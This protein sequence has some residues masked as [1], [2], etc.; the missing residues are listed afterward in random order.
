MENI[1][2]SIA[3]ARV[4]SRLNQREFADKI[5]VSHL[6]FGFDF[7]EFLST[8]S[9][10]SYSDQDTSYTVGLEDCSKL[11]TLLEK[12]KKIGFSQAELEQIC[13]K[14]WHHLIQTVLG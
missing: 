11:P 5:G 10:K 8:D 2:I 9:M 13:Y 14:N 4:N 6:A 3:A 1:R 12:L 7:F